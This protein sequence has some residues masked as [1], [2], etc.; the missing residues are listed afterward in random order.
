MRRFLFCSLMLLLIYSGNAQNLTVMTYNIRLD[1]SGDGENQWDNRKDK[2]VNQLRFYEPDIF[3]IQEG[4]PN[5]V[6]YLDENL[7]AY[8]YIGV[9][10]DDGKEKGEFSAIY[11][12]DQNFKL[13]KSGTFW[14]STTPEK[15]SVGWDAALPRVCTYGL[16][17]RKSDQQQFWVF[18]THF[19]HV[20]K[21]A[22]V[23][24]MKVI[25]EQIGDL[26]EDSLPVVLMGDLNVTPG[27][28]PILE[29]KKALSDTRDIAG[30]VFGPDATFNEFMFDETPQRRIDYIAVNE[31]KVEVLKYAVLTDSYDQKYI[32]DHFP[33]F[34]ELSFKD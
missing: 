2:L 6:R 27:E 28:E 3:G 22:R 15:P 30:V 21:E 26:N 13:V 18:N 1:Y 23:N 7:E 12:Q 25:L 32:S 24:S 11:Y 14:L 20:G 33:V 10:R 29:M 8:S 17:Q 34:C 19:D 9:G 31:N 16:F 5:Q 4:L